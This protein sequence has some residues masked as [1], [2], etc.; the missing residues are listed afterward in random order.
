MKSAN[1]NISEIARRYASALLSLAEEGR[2]LKAVEKD[3]S[4][5]GRMFA[6]N[7]DLQDMLNAPIISDED[8]A[9]ALLALAK[10][11]KLGKLVTNFIGTVADNGRASELASMVEAFGDM[12][13]KKRGV[14]TAMVVSAQKLSAAELKSIAN[15]LKK[16]LGKSVKIETSI[17]PDLLGGFIV[18]V[19]SKYFDASVKTRLDGL[20]LALKE[21]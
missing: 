3:M 14:E 16:T 21:A 18:Q 6:N 20:K 7:A 5:L 15:N 10:K 9:K 4:I 1:K 2:G 17:N 12:L 8:K 19:G 11:A 13:A